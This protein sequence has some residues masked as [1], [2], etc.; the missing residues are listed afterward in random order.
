MFPSHRRGIWHR[1]RGSPLAKWSAWNAW[2][3]PGMCGLRAP[4]VCVSGECLHTK[5]DRFLPE[6]TGPV[7]QKI[8][9]RHSPPDI[10]TVGVLHRSQNFSSAP[11]FVEIPTP[12]HL[13]DLCLLD[14]FSIF[15][16]LSVCVYVHVCGLVVNISPVHLLWP[17]AQP[18][19]LP[20]KR[21]VTLKPSLPMMSVTFT[22]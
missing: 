18:G 3:I 1:E 14:L 10:L 5:R 7:G 22:V 13:C 20:R 4:T 11:N 16:T 21:T 17:T 12:V 9:S 2:S 8:V 19:I 6:S 15:R